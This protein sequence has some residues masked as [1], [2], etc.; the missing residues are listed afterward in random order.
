MSQKSEQNIYDNPAFFDGYY[1][2]R[3][4]DTCLNDLVEQPAM[5]ALLPDTRGKSVLDLGCGY[6]RNCLAFARQGAARVVGLDISEKMLAV[7]RRESGGATV[8]Y[9]RMSMT[10][11]ASLAGAFDLVYSSLAFHYIED[12]PQLADDIYRLLRPGGHL[13]FSQEH[14]IITAT[15]DGQGGWNRGPD[16]APLSYT[17]SNYCQSGRRESHWFIDGVVKYHRPMG[18]ILTTLAK[19]G[20]VLEEVCE[21]VPPPWA[22]EK[23][24]AA[25]KEFLKPNFLIVK[26]S[27]R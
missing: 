24:P 27:K 10:E 18:E 8:E 6:G 16:G 5:A 9:L 13:L 12:F 25:A 21:P 7:A 4:K 14:P 23:L 17:F 19:A 11:L 26:A 22:L 15:V 3:E 1:A 2:L 20:F